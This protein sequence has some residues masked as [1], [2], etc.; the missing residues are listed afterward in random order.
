VLLIHAQD[1]PVIPFEIFE[2]PEVGRNPNIE[3]IA[4]EHGGHLGFLARR[5]P[6]FW[7]ERM[8]MDWIRERR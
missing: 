6:R 8:V 7:A 1:D 4:V 5:P 2:R 3:L